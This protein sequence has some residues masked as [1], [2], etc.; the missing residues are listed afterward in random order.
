VERAATER[1]SSTAYKAR[2]VGWELSENEGES[3]HSV[4]SLGPVRARFHLEVRE[5]IRHG[6]HGLALFNGERQLMWAWATDNLSLEPGVHA[7]TY[8]FPFLPLRPGMYSWQVS[9]FMDHQPLDIWDAIPE[10]VIAAPNQQHHRDEWNGVLNVPSSFS[11][12]SGKG[13]F[14]ARTGS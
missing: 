4:T 11:I 14:D 1:D 2:F 8:D 5:A 13:N 12:I 9:I 6:H 10:L 3:Q 7:L